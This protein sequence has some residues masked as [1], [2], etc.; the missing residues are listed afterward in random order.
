MHSSA[1]QNSSFLGFIVTN[2]SNGTLSVSFIDLGDPAPHP[3][4]ILSARIS[5]CMRG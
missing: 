2:G 1:E 5:R 3:F 4:P